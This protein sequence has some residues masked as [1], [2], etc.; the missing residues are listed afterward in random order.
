MQY[1][2]SA[3]A[4][5]LG[6]EGGW[7][8]RGRGV[9]LSQPRT[10]H[11]RRTALVL[12]A[13]LNPPPPQLRRLDG[14]PAPPATCAARIT[15]GPSCHTPRPTAP[16]RECC[17]PSPRPHRAWRSASENTA[18]VGMPSRRAVARTRQAISP[19]LAC[20]CG[21]MGTCG[22]AGA[23]CER[24]KGARSQRLTWREAAARAPRGGES[25]PC[26]TPDRVGSCSAPVGQP[27]APPRRT[28]RS[29]RSVGVP[30]AA[31]RAQ[32]SAAPFDAP[33]IQG[34]C[35]PAPPPYVAAAFNRRTCAA[36]TRADRMARENPLEEEREWLRT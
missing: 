2:S 5:C 33:A 24:G 11:G 34:V 19:R 26:S 13:C 35:C 23:G 6:G 20:E 8:P 17:P 27:C 3:S 9:A 15:R 25:G 1:A 21:G 4:T 7:A 32:V 14:P 28:T 22:G 18:T 10:S 16:G 36:A 29:L 31:P 12:A 30:D